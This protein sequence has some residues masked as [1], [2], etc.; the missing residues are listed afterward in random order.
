MGRGERRGEALPTGTEG[1]LVGQVVVGG[2]H[3]AAAVCGHRCLV[4]GQGQIG[5]RM[6]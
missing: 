3:E 6:L 4:A 5:K 1:Q 2:A